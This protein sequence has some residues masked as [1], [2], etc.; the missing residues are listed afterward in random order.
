MDI[1]PKFSI[2]K[3]LLDSRLS[4]VVVAVVVLLVLAF[5]YAMGARIVYFLPDYPVTQTPWDRIGQGFDEELGPYS[6]LDKC[7]YYGSCLNLADGADLDFLYYTFWVILFYFAFI[8]GMEK[9]WMRKLLGVGLLGVSYL[10]FAFLQFHDWFFSCS[11]FCG[12]EHLFMWA[13]LLVVYILGIATAF[14]LKRRAKKM[15]LSEIK[16]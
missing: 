11:D 7:L 3:Y 8:S 6:G 5:Q 10:A 12:I 14:F 16:L 4:I 9:S 15:N 2:R 1:E 13:P